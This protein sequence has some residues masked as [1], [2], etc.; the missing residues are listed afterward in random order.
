MATS[1][2]GYGTGLG[3]LPAGQVL[4]ARGSNGTSWMSPG[5]SVD[6]QNAIQIGNPNPV[7][8]FAMNGNITTPTGTISADDWITVIQ[9]MKRLIMDMSQD[10][11]IISKYPYI[12]D[13]A[14]TWLINEL[15][16]KDDGNKEI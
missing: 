11:D 15:K 5:T 12:Q 10:Q 3:H 9:T 7:I 8:T 6:S 13:V 14:H 2:S 1:K 16:G 4:T